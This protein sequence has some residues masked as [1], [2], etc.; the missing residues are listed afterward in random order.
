MR[1]EKKDFVEQ[2]ENI[3]SISEKEAAKIAVAEILAEFGIKNDDDL[4]AKD[5]E[6]IAELYENLKAGVLE[7]YDMD[8]EDI[9]GILEELLGQ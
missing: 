8:E 6:E 7:E 2:E 5:G 9:E 4:Y 3:V 1:T